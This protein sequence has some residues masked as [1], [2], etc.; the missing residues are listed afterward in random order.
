[1]AG[2]IN[3]TGVEFYLPIISFLL[4]FVVVFAILAKTKVLG[5]SKWVQLLISFLTSIIFV[6]AVGARNYILNVTP[7]TIVFIVLLALVFALIGFAGK[8]LEGMTKGIGVVF[9][10]G[11]LVL[12]L[13]SAYY[14]FSSSPFVVSLKEWASTPKV[15]GALILLV[16]GGIVSWVLIKLK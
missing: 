12:F 2:E 3:L 6:S 10:I 11:L 5:E 14:T 16:V 4:V 9:V 15:Y 13:V 8:P 1:M 7:W